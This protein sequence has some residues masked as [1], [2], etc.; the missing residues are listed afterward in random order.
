MSAVVPQART[1]NAAGAVS[2]IGDGHAGPHGATLFDIDTQD[3]GA[4]S[5]EETVSSSAQGRG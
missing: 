5:R 1:V 2:G 4:V 3:G